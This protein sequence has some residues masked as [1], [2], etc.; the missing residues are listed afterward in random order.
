MVM[1][2]DSLLWTPEAR[3]RVLPRRSHGVRVALPEGREARDAIDAVYALRR[4]AIVLGATHADP[5]HA[6]LQQK[7]IAH[8]DGDGPFAAVAAAAAALLVLFEREPAPGVSNETLSRS[9]VDAWLERGGP[10]LAVL[11][12]A[13]TA[14]FRA[15]R[16][17]GDHSLVLDRHV[18]PMQYGEPLHEPAERR[19]IALRARH[20]TMPDADY[21]AA[22]AAAAKLLP[23]ASPRLA[24]RLVY[25]FPDEAAWSAALA[26]ALLAGTAHAHFDL[27]LASLAD[28]ALVAEVVDHFHD[29][30]YQLA[31]H[32]Y[33]LADAL[34]LAAAGPLVAI[35]ES[36][37]NVH[38][39]VEE[40]RRESA[41]A[42]ALVPT[43][44]VAQWL[45]TRLDDKAIRAPASQ[46]FARAPQ[47]AITTLAPIVAGP[48]G[49]KKTSH[50]HAAALL[51]SVVR[52]APDTARAAV[53]EL[54]GPA[55]RL[56]LDLIAAAAVVAE[57][58]PSAVPPLL[59][60]PPWAHGRPR[61]K[62]KSGKP[63]ALELSPLAFA[64]HLEEGVAQ[65]YPAAADET[66]A[67]ARI[68]RELAAGS[69]VFLFQL[70][71]V[72]RTTALALLERHPTSAWCKSYRFDEHLATAL[73]Q[74]GIE[75]LGPLLRFAK[76][77]P[78]EVAAGLEEAVS[79]RV[80]PVMAHVLARVRKH[81]R[82][83]ERW[84]VRHPRAAAV[85]LLPELVGKGSDAKARSNAARALRFLAARGQADTL[86]EVASEYGSPCVSA[87][88]ATLADDALADLAPKK[89][90]RLPAWLGVGSLP[91]PRLEGAP[92]RSLPLAAVQSLCEMLAFTD[93]EEPYEGL[94]QVREACDAVSLGDFAWGIFEA[95]CLAGNPM[96]E[97]W[98]FF[99]IGHLG[100][101][102]H[103]H[104]IAALVRQWPSDGAF[105][106]AVVG[107]DVL[108]TM[109]SDAAF[110]LLHGIG[111][112]VK[113]RPLQNRA[114]EKM[115]SVAESLGL[116]VDELADRL[117]P[118]LGLDDDGARV[119]DFGPRS[120]R[121]GFDEHLRPFVRDAEGARLADLPKPG[122]SDDEAK[123]TAASAQW[124]SLKKA[125]KA[126]AGQQVERLQ[127]A[128]IAQR[129]WEPATFATYLAGHP[130]VAH[131]VRRLVFGVYDGAGGLVASFRVAEDGTYAGPDDE[132]LTL[133]DGARIGVLHPLEISVAAVATWGERLS[134]YE[135]LQPFPQLGRDVPRSI[136]RADVERFTPVD[137]LKLLGLERRGWRRGPVG[138][139]GIVDE[140]EKEAGP[141]RVALQLVPG[142]YAGDPRMNPLQT[143]QSLEFS[144]EPGAI[145]LAEV[146]ADL[147]AVGAVTSSP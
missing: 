24:A 86:A 18:T 39:G 89:P 111:E 137:T 41:A 91:R 55:A 25:A 134:E 66:A 101:D 129:R 114:I 40:E 87:L 83:A 15:R 3:A 58:E 147:R 85:G 106:R 64:E 103:A 42:V 26:R 34:Q 130:L 135:I 35:A 108:A 97:K 113:S 69:H 124:K 6:S 2:A 31:P 78:G 61:S 131:L 1:A 20:A 107:L 98:A 65:E 57:A 19:W 109:K 127:D 92:P 74:I 29:G 43:P 14:A 81:R 52:A 140:V 142:I 71:M 82:V 27:L 63:L 76:E 102:E 79:P 36:A 28:P 88:A 96:N 59:A 133:P 80:A 8:L 112:R 126:T 93:H 50:E 116:G 141:L 122:K 7:A 68:E 119:L 128:M 95:W 117:V 11:A 51:A 54:V 84:L 5:E 72:S 146:A 10:A 16:D 22:R 56:V 70:P 110:M 144:G 120:F 60:A 12:C 139:G 132:T 33:D 99:A 23:N 32:V 48:A 125:A 13:A 38:W 73:A 94:E 67:L 21:A 105:P 138:D 49:K 115:E 143:P 37:A 4:D 121:V 45:A 46:L 30:A 77:R 104:R 145:F 62:K 17:P 100:R 90:P 136:T 9:L 118:T 44:Q 47:L 75:A 123:A 53:E